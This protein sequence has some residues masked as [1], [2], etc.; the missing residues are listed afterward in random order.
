MLHAK[1]RIILLNSPGT[2]ICFMCTIG[3]PKIKTNKNDNEQTLN[4]QWV[5]SL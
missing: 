5:V 3:I 4:F 1:I 2:L